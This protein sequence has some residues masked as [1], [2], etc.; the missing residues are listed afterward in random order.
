MKEDTFI[1]AE[2]GVNHNGDIRLAY[3]L[4]DVAKDAGVDCVKFQTYVTEN[5][6]SRYC[7]KADYQ[8]TEEEENQFEM[9]KKLELSFDEFRLLKEYCEEK[10]IL[11]LSTPFDITSL[12]FLE[13]LKMPIW[14]IAS[15]EVENYPLL[16]E[17]GKTHKEVILS[18]GMCNMGEIEAAIGVLKKYG[19]T[20]IS[21]LHCNTEYPTPMEDVNLRAMY[22][23][24]EKFGCEVGYSDHTNGVE[25][26]IAAVAMGAKIIEK[27]FTLDKGMEG[28]DHAAS[29]NPKELKDMVQGIRNVEK[30]LGNG[31]KE[32]SKSEKKNRIVA[33]KSIVAKK[34]IKK[35]EVFSEENIVAKRPGGGINPMQWMDVIGRKAIRDFA[36]D[37]MIEL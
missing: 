30:A 12:K 3:Q 31:R 22:E 5:D 32:P 6:T 19:S 11:F 10:G 21:L 37:E 17:I 7:E 20:K 35:G 14:K 13:S 15:S 33:R 23:L 27:H 16:R 25:V 28:P 36:E 29:L 24:A 18:T 34:N 1:I 9:L 8:K 2:A 4:I 26:P